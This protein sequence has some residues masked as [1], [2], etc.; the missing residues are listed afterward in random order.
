MAHTRFVI[1]PVVATLILMA[2]SSGRAD[3]RVLF[4]AYLDSP[5]HQARV[6]ELWRQEGEFL[7]G[8]GEEPEQLGR[9]GLWIFGRLRFEDGPDPVDGAW[10]QRMRGQSCG[11]ESTYN[12][13]F[14]AASDGPPKGVILIPGMSDADFVLQRDVMQA[15]VPAAAVAAGCEAESG[16]GREFKVMDTARDSAF[17]GV[18]GEWQEIWDV[19]VCETDVRLDV[20]FSPDGKGGTYFN[21]KVRK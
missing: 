2:A 12:F 10:M 7:C 11:R 20:T 5:D 14:A 17:Q 9:V 19:R 8:Q 18:R 15:V 16:D 1:I 3:D 4:Q 6:L 21:V 13:L